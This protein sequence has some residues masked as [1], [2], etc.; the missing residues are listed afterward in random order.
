MVQ[1]LVARDLFK[2]KSVVRF[3]AVEGA[4]HIVAI[5]PRHLANGIGRHA[6]FRIRK[7][8]QIEPIASPP[9]TIMRRRQQVIHHVAIPVHV[10]AAAPVLPL[11]K[12][13]RNTNKVK[14]GATNECVAIGSGRKCQAV[15]LQPGQNKMIHRFRCRHCRRRLKG[16]VSAFFVSDKQIGICGSNVGLYITFRR[17]GGDPLTDNFDLS[18]RGTFHKE[19]QQQLPRR[20]GFALD[21]LDHQTG[22]RI[23]GHDRR[24]IFAALSHRSRTSKIHAALPYSCTVTGRAAQQHDRQHVM[25]SD[26]LFDRSR[27]LLRPRPVGDPCADR[28]TFFVGQPRLPFRRHVSTVDHHPQ[29]TVV[30]RIRDRCVARFTAAANSAH[31]GQIKPALLHV[32]AVTLAAPA[33]KDRLDIRFKDRCL[34]ISAA[35]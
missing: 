2:Q 12:A 20:A 34:F 11:V 1:Q 14:I 4:N 10:T 9:F 29:Q 5:F 7:A 32:D 35:T 17:A 30:D 19:L 27:R 16:P 23:A 21:A 15:F 13:G 8:S 26:H 24:T 25:L 33:G 28:C 31:R 22:S 18:S 6:A 3:V